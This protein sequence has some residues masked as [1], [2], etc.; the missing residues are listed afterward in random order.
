MTPDQARQF[1]ED[2]RRA[3]F[4]A[5][6][7]R[8]PE[9]DLPYLCRVFVDG[10]PSADTPNLRAG[11]LRIV[12]EGRTGSGSF[13]VADV[14]DE[15]ADLADQIPACEGMGPILRTTCREHPRG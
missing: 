2:V 11:L 4:N 8:V 1:V 14:L 3:V 10:D 6:S 7:G 5:A 12:L 13:T 9:A 15:M